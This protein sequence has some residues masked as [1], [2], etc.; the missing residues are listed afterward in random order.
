MH[1]T[2]EHL[3]A[4]VFGAPAKRVGPVSFLKVLLAQPKICQLYVAIQINEDVLRLQVPVY[5]ISLMQVLYRKYDLSNYDA[6]LI[7]AETLLL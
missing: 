3:W 5:D 6:C 2:V 7:L 4:D 1:P